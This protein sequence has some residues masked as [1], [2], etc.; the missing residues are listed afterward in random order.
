MIATFDL[1]DFVLSPLLDDLKRIKEHFPGFRITLFT[2]AMPKTVRTG[3]TPY[4]KY[5]KWFEVVQ[6]HDWIEIAPH[7]LTHEQGEMML[8]KADA[9]ARIDAVE[10]TFNELG[11]KYVK[12]WKSPFWQ[13][14]EATLEV[15]RDKGYTVCV[16]PNQPD[17]VVPGLKTFKWNWS[18]DQPVPENVKT[19]HAHGHCYG[20]NNDLKQCTPNIMR[21]MPTDL[22]FKTIG[23]FLDL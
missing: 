7:G 19:L 1:D 3:E 2:I 13:S 5:K 12:V 14:S 9:E 6:E 10:S 15:L 8:S 11:V 18:I 4:E 21:H 23:E 16:D 17:P 22:E 20:T